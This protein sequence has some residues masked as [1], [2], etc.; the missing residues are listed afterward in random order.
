M[1][2]LSQKQG[3]FVTDVTNWFK[4]DSDK[5]KAY[6]GG[7]LAGTGKSTVLP[8]ILDDIGLKPDEVLAMAPTGKAAKVMTDKFKDQ[9]LPLRAST[10]HSCIYTPNA[11][12]LDRLKEDIEIATRQREAA[13]FSGDET[14]VTQLTRRINVLER[15]FDRQIEKGDKPFFSLRPDSEKMEKA[16]LLIV[17]EAS[18]INEEMAADIMS[19]GIPVYATGD[20][21]QLPPVEGDQWFREDNCDFFLTEIHRQA[22]D[23]P[24]IQLA[25]DARHGKAI[26]LGTYGDTVRVMRRKDD[27]ITYDINKD[28]T[29]IC[30]TNAKRYAIT[31]KL[32]RLMGCDDMQGPYE[33]EPLMICRNSRRYPN[34]INGLEVVSATDHPEMHD[35]HPDFMVSIMVDGQAR[36]VTC[37]QALFEYHYLG[38]GKYTCGKHD[39]YRA[40]REAEHIDFAHAITCHKSQGSQWEH[41]VVHDESSVFQ[42]ERNRWLYTALTRAEMKLD[43]IT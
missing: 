36:N 10:I 12:A 19:Y 20:P 2:Q 29:L 35:G 6:R 38:K 16:K 11:S 18:M 25:H 8:F 21:G 37:V 7:G 27:D 5:K 34:H 42:E 1:I 28:V 43:I 3:E 40:L 30:G 9:G 26:K 14:K 24:I 22:A 17:D 39:L 23:N 31:R 33:G 4:N 15:D 41:V 32:R 13:A